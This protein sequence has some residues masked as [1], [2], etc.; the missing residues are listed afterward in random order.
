PRPEP[1]AA[2]SR[3]AL[4]E[5]PRRLPEIGGGAVRRPEPRP[6]PS[7]ESD[8]KKLIVGR[9]I[10]LTG[11]IRACERMVVEGRVEASLTDSRTIEIAQSGV[12]KGAAQIDTA[13]ISGRF[14]G[15][16][17]VRERLVLRSTG[18]IEGSVRYGEIEIERGGVI[19]GEIEQLPEGSRAMG[20]SLPEAPARL[21]EPERP[22]EPAEGR[23]AATVGALGVGGA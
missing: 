6:A 18:R 21:V 14:E 22:A 11:E 17:V 10:V 20:T 5:V 4:V 12:F 7:A 15:D 3:P 13:D 16:L 1:A 9:E 8:G 23:I 19:C 2:A